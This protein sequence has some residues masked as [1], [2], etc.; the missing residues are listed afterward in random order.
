MDIRERS[1]GC[2]LGGAMGDAFGYPIE[3]MSLGKIKAAYG[4]D[5]L[6]DPLLVDSHIDRRINQMNN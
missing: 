5:G 2:L 4:N 3:F 1:I 6:R